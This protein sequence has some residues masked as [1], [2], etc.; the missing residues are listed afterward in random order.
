MRKSLYNKFVITF[1]IVFI[2][3]SIVSFSTVFLFKYRDVTNKIESKLYSVAINMA[4][5]YT[6]LS[7]EQFTKAIEL[8]TLSEYGIKI[9]KETEFLKSYGKNVDEMNILREDI[10]KLIY[11]EK[12]ISSNTKDIFTSNCTYVGVPFKKNNENYELFLSVRGNKQIVDIINSARIGM[13]INLGIQILIFYIII[14]YLVNPINE[15]S[16]AAEKISK[17][18]Y[19]VKIKYKSKDEIGYLIK[20]FNF[21]A[22]ELSKVENLRRDFVSS[23][24]HEI[25]SPITSIMGFGK[26]LQFEKD[27]SNIKRYAKIIEDESKRLSNLSKNLLKLTVLENEDFEKERYCLDEQLRRVILNLEPIWQR[28]DIKFNVELKNKANI[29]ANK[30]LMEQVLI[31]IISNS[32]KFSKESGEID[33]NLIEKNNSY[34]I[35]IKDYGIGMDEETIN[36]AFEKFFK[37]D[38]SRKTEGSGLGLSIVK[39]IIDIHGGK[40]DINSNLE[41]GTV[42]NVILNKD[43][44][45]IIE[46]S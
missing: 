26:L 34:E 2:L 17:G 11:G 29:M 22:K 43:D 16:K 42:I 37:G 41:E 30:D 6:E 15:L 1:I 44:N 45:N 8:D 10:D 3:G 5:L 7:E 36:K 35:L 9:F 13:I 32:I 20:N 28:K 23:V 46:E 31:N 33:V 21:M 38:K 19:D 25:Q 12:F 27:S 4:D 40:V 14:R 24:S 18:D 39:K